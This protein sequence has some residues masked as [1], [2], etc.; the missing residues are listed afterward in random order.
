MWIFEE[1]V[2]PH[3]QELLSGT[4]VNSDAKT[5]DDHHYYFIC[6]LFKVD[7]QLYSPP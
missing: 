4:V 5:Y 1:C 2:V 3:L 6:V 7:L